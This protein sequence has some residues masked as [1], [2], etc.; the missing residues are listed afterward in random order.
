MIENLT[1]EKLNEYGFN[2]D[3]IERLLTWEDY[4][5]SFHNLPK[6]IY[7]AS[8]VEQK[9]YSGT[10]AERKIYFKKTYEA[11]PN[12][13]DL[14][15][16]Y[17]ELKKSRYLKDQKTKGGKLFN[18]KAAIERFIQNEIV[19]AENTIERRWKWENFAG[20]KTK[21]EIIIMYVDWLKSYKISPREETLLS[22]LAD[23]NEYFESY[24]E[25]YNT[26]LKTASSFLPKTEFINDEIERVEKIFIQK[27]ITTIIDGGVKVAEFNV[28]KY[29]KLAY[30]WL[31]SGQNW[32]IQRILTNAIIEYSQ[33]K[34]KSSFKFS[35]ADDIRD[36]EE[37]KKHILSHLKSGVAY[38]QYQ[39]F[40]KEQLGLARE[41]VNIEKSIDK[42]NGDEKSTGREKVNLALIFNEKNNAFEVCKGLFEYHEITID[43]KLN[44]YKLKKGR[45]GTLTG[46]ITAIKE[47]PGMLKLDNATEL[48]LLNYFNAYLNTDYKTF[49]KRNNYYQ[50]SIDTSHRFIKQNFKK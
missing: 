45:V 5:T 15:Q 41:Q 37:M 3:Q 47:T 18:E 1:V 10:D 8:N 16:E 30:D 49:S 40:L 2:K 48:Q 6:G 23:D 19:L 9:I 50:E 34:K 43:G 20:V 7:W 42:F 44:P 35:E 46:L 38:L 27:S 13:P 21:N 39:K 36:N 4:E 26:K 33:Y 11:Y 24:V 28:S 31:K 22:S 32:E 14:I 29:T 12:N 17:F 25:E